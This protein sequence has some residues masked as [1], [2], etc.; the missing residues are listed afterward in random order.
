MQNNFILINYLRDLI[1]NDNVSDICLRFVCMIFRI[2]FSDCKLDKVAV[3]S[4]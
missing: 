2:L 4:D 1:E 3:N